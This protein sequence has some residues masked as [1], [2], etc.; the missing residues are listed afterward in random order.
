MSEILKFH[1][2]ASWKIVVWKTT[3]KMFFTFFQN[4]DVKPNE[5]PIRNEYRKKETIHTPTC[6]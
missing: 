1:L 3:P 6:T 5:P 4:Y 2:T